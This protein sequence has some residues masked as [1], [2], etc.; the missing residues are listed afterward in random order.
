M[1]TVETTHDI[2][3]GRTLDVFQ[4]ADLLMARALERHG[5]EIDIIAYY[6]SYA[7]GVARDSSDLDIFYIPAEGK[8]PPVGRTFLIN[9]ILFDFWAIDWATMAGFATG[10][11]RG[12]SFA[13]AIVHHAK[14]LHARTAEQAARLAAL[15]QNV[16]DLQKPAARPQ[17]IQRAL[18]EFRNVLAHLGNLRLAVAAGDFADV[19]H[20]GWQVI[21]STWECLALANQVFF[22]R[23][24]G[25]ILEQIPR[26]PARPAALESL[27]ITI[28]T[29]EDP[30]LIADAAE[31]LALCTRQLLREFQQSLVCQQPTCAVF[32]GSYPEIKDGLG[33]V[34]AA[35]EG[36]RPVAASAAAWFAQVDLSLMLNALHNSASHAHFNLY[37]EFALLY[38]QLGFPDL[39]PATA[40]DLPKLA[41][42]VKVLDGRVRQW[43]QEQSVALCEF[44]TLE[45]FARSL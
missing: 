4:V 43:L 5:D 17:M 35:C 6:G 37:R 32:D 9:G 27:M 20:A 26:L 19:R 8:N 1:T 29:A 2:T 22:D 10:R 42:Q 28:S 40:G 39:M 36:Q 12:W 38:R 34:I 15:K 24:W 33:K 3:K 18:D 11:I 30:N 16:L 21:L 13:P 31:K 41:D 23:G 25:H 45:E 14:V 7:Q 44:A